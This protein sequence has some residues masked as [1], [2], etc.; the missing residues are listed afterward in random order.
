MK[1]ELQRL[2][3]E[4][5]NIKKDIDNFLKT[6]AESLVKQLAKGKITEE[7]LRDKVSELIRGTGDIIP[8]YRFLVEEAKK[9][10]IALN[11][12]KEGLAKRLVEKAREGFMYIGTDE[13]HEAKK[14]FAEAGMEG[15]AKKCKELTGTM[16]AISEDNDAKLDT[17]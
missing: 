1:E 8:V 7:E 4:E 16:F 6:E 5:K 11:S 12:V 10:G 9:Q 17:F 14:L 13:L 3:N 2:F 15:E